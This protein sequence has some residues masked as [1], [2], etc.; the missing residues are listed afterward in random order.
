[1]DPSIVAA[2][3]VSKEALSITGAKPGSTFVHIW[4]SE[5]IRTISVAVIKKRPFRIREEK[6]KLPG[7]LES[8]KF[9]YNFSLSDTSVDSKFSQNE[10]MSRNSAHNFSLK[11]ESPWGKLD[12]RMQFSGR[13]DKRR[14]KQDDVTYFH[15]NLKDEDYD[16]T[17]GDKRINF[18]SLTLPYVQYQGVN[19]KTTLN[20]KVDYNIVWGVEGQG[21]YGDKVIDQYLPNPYF[22]GLRT[23]FHTSKNLGISTTFLQGRGPSNDTSQEVA[24]SECNLTLDKLNLRSEYALAEGDNAWETEARLNMDKTSFGGIYRDYDAG[25]KTVVGGVGNRG[26]KG[27]YLSFSHNSRSFFDVSGYCDIFRDRFAPNLAE[28]KQNNVNLTGNIRLNLTPL[29]TLDTSVWERDRKGSSSPTITDGANYQLTQRFD[30]GKRSIYANLIYTT[31]EFKSMPTPSADFDDKKLGIGLRAELIE[32]L[33][34]SLTQEW[35]QK[36]ELLNGNESTPQRSVVGLDYNSRVGK[37]PFYTNLRLRYENRRHASSSGG[38]FV[39][40][41]TVSS[42]AEIRYR[43]SRDFEYFIRGSIADVKGTSLNQRSRVK[44][45]IYTGAN[46]YWDTGFRIQPAG[47]VGGVIFKDINGNGIRD[48]GELG[49]PNVKISI[50]RKLS[51]L[52]DKEGRYKF[53]NVKGLKVSVLMELKDIPLG[54]ISTSGNPQKVL[55]QSGKVSEVNFGITIKMKASGIVFN[56]L[57]GNKYFDEEDKGIPNVLISI[58]DKGVIT[59]SSGSY[60]VKDILA[61]GYYAT[62]D[63]RTLP[64]N[65]ILLVPS[66]QKIIISEGEKAYTYNFAVQALRTII[67]FVFYDQNGNGHL[68]DGEKGIPDIQVRMDGQVT[69][70]DG[71]GEYIFKNLSAGKHQVKLDKSSL[72]AQYYL[73]TPDFCTIDLSAESETMKD[74]NFGM[75]KK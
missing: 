10:Y 70:T 41:D 11:G 40:E 65:F 75:Q 60:I 9:S 6:E 8:F 52:T 22:S 56:D 20:E 46:Y 71:K 30:V 36:R 15:L 34:I 4:D 27:I 28:P 5:G 50:D 12:S 24:A 59:D 49:V 54:Y 7:E 58:G 29:T 43:P 74:V 35:Y 51:M 18:S 21:L 62:L 37:S 2:K 42:E 72:P 68:D 69:L 38:L 26:H 23:T 44:R 16:F 3:L 53:T 25:Y 55:I 19:L 32:K 13:D 45:E 66:K 48:K 64:R 14:K 73:T 47:T 33:R 67:G 63:E 1:M 61:G 39:D 57:N 31:R 17:L